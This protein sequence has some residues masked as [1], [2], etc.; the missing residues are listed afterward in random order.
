MKKP[1]FLIITSLV[2][3]LLVNSGFISSTYATD[4]KFVLKEI[5][6]I[7]VE[8]LANDVHAEGDT[9][10]LLDFNEGFLIYN[11][12]ELANPTLLGSYVGN[13]DI[14]PNVKGGK[15]FYIRGD[16]VIVGFMGAGLKIFDVSDPT[17]LALVGE[18]FG[19][20]IYHIKVVD[21]LVYMA[22][23]DDGFQIIDISDI[24]RPTKVGEFNN[25]NPL[26][27][28]HII[29]NIAYLRDYVQD[30][31]LCLDVTDPSNI[32]EI[33]QFDWAAYRIEMDEDIGYLCAIAGG[34]LAYN[35]SDPTEPIF[36]DEHNDG[37]DSSDIVIKEN[38]A[39]VADL[40]D[41]LEILDITDPGNLTEIAQFNDG[42]GSRNVFVDGNVAYVSEF[43]DGLE[44]IQ[45][46]EEEMDSSD[47]ISSNNFI[48]SWEEEMNSSDSIPSFKL[49]LVL[50]GLIT[51][52]SRVVKCIF[53]RKK[54]C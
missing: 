27:H 25:G 1:K 28:I 39:F 3:A 16:H 32:T 36:L 6:H 46:W 54:S 30:K 42:G 15:T 33:G 24:T 45:L 19:G 47:S 44:I 10:Y 40:D 8:G 23:A 43:E 49:L 21:D 50:L 22:M 52:R 5:G 41:G 2:V 31:T 35:F 51:L 4:Q 37:G 38:L 11:I 34:V 13:N 14:D 26:Y 9:V 53:R 48:S 18:Y 20:K 17:N 7:H 12:S 29:G